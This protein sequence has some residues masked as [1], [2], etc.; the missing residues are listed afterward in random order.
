MRVRR[1]RVRVRLWLK[2]RVGVRP[3]TMR[4]R[5]TAREPRF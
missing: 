5:S 1:V 2:V 3:W 4:A